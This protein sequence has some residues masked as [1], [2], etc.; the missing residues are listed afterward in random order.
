MEGKSVRGDSLEGASRE[1]REIVRFARG[2]SF[3]IACSLTA[4]VA[5]VVTSIVLTHFLVRSDVGLFAQAHAL[6]AMGSLLGL[7]GMRSALTRFVAMYRADSDIAAVHGVV[8]MGIGAAA[9][10]GIGLGVTAYLFA[11][12]L[13][14]NVFDDADLAT[15]FRWAALILPGSTIMVAATSA[16]QGFRNVRPFNV[17]RRLIEPGV[18]LVTVSAVLWFGGDVN[19]AMAASAVTTWLATFVAL[20]WLWRLMGPLDGKPTYQ[21]GTVFRFAFVSW[22]AAFAAQGLLWADILMVGWLRPSADVALYQIASRVA[23]LAALALPPI[24]AVMAPRAADLFRRHKKD[25]AASIYQVSSAWTLRLTL[26]AAV[27]ILVMPTPILSIFGSEYRVAVAAMLIIIPGQLFDALT[28]ATATLL[29]M[30]GE[31]MSTLIGNM[32]TLTLNIAL[33]AILIPQMG[34]EG[35]ALAWTASLIIVNSYRTIMV[36]RRI[37]S[38]WPWSKASAKAALAGIAAAAV[39]FGRH[40]LVL[41]GRSDVWVI[42]PVGFAIVVTYLGIII[43]QG[44]DPADRVLIDRFLPRDG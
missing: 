25:E 34:I 6:S 22:G 44:L 38:V 31:N 26:P 13:A 39:G 20:A 29:N 32:S 19:D 41:V 14:V 35:A 17:V 15:P 10:A 9:L 12:P 21:P 8:R 30:A 42:V 23:L 36:R 40:Q 7:V 37:F 27:A 33:N 5:L 1:D 16:T 3:S 11:E 43:A 28:G 24:N 2:S 18:K 4:Q